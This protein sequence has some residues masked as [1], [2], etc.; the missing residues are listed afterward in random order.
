MRHLLPTRDRIGV[1]IDGSQ[2]IIARHRATSSQE[3]APETVDVGEHEGIAEPRAEAGGRR[4]PCMSERLW[5]VLPLVIHAF[6]MISTTRMHP[7]KSSP[8][9][10]RMHGRNSGKTVRA[11]RRYW[12]SASWVRIAYFFFFSSSALATLGELTPRIEL[13][14]VL[15]PASASAFRTWEQNL[16]TSLAKLGGVW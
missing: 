8:A 16:V 10:E 6:V 13:L 14:M 12:R 5:S 15:W 9:W 3:L 2:V 4:L 7:L 11:P 1:D